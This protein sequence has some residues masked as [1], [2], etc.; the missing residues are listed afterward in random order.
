M[1]ATMQINGFQMHYEVTGSGPNLLLL[2]GLGSSAEDWEYQ[3][4]AC[5]MHH[6]VVAC[7][8]RG[9]GRSE[10]PDGPYSIAGFATDVAAL[11][12]ALAIERIHVV[13]ISMGGMVALQLAADRPDLID[14]LVIV[15]SAGEVVPSGL[16]WL[17]VF[18]RLAITRVF[19]LPRMGRVVARKLFPSEAQ[20][21]LRETFAS[22]F[23]RNDKHAYLNSVHAIVGWSVR[24]RLSAIDA[25]TL[26][27]SG[28]RDY[29]PVSVK[30][31]FVAEMPDAQLRVVS[32][33]GHATPMDQPGVFNDMVLD[34]LGSADA[35]PVHQQRGDGLHA[36][37][38]A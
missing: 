16:Q 33:S 3:R 27:V 13:G 10:R 18:Q 30:E 15:N 25:P 19:G 22:R 23:G 35:Q 4:D 11:V 5:A 29:T 17:A 34:F 38:R 37:L 21:E 6:R 9:H 31:P 32:D 28:D 7:D 26:W 2:H 1:M 14:R 36:A 8:L 24:E 20:R 12:D